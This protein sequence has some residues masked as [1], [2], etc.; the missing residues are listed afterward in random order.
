VVFCCFLQ[1]TVNI[2]DENQQGQ[3][4]QHV[5]TENSDVIEFEIE[6]AIQQVD[7]KTSDVI[8]V[9]ND[10]QQTPLHVAAKSGSV[11]CVKYLIEVSANVRA[12]DKDFKTPLHLAAE[13][14]HLKCVEELARVSDINAKDYNLNTPL[15]LA[16]KN[17]DA[18]FLFILKHPKVDTNLNNRNFKTGKELA[19]EYFL[20]RTKSEK[21]SFIKNWE[22]N[23]DDKMKEMST[24]DQMVHLLKL[25]GIK[26]RKGNETKGD[27]NCFYRA[28]ADQSSTSWTHSML[29][30]MVVEHVEK[31]FNAPP[32][33][34]SETMNIL[35]GCYEYE[36]GDNSFREMIEKQK[37]NT[38]W[39][40]ETFI[41]YTANLLGIAIR[42]FKIE[43]GGLVREELFPSK[44]MTES[45]EDNTSHICIAHYDNH[46][47]SVLI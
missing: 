42:V 28:V 34:R 43:E 24:G 33:L 9:E 18:T 21:T 11:A 2:D 30:K 7:N 14:G 36:N 27:G 39:A 25:A 1:T 8:D 4:N 40:N 26:V 46:F 6:S 5:E 10:E 3:Q 37:E 20:F 29:R 31:E 47:Q 23:K 32:N 12:R 41:A 16:A 15:H 22:Q 38:I 35:I 19:M 45:E 13:Q 44:L 17:N